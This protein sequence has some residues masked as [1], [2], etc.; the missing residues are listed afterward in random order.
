MGVKEKFEGDVAVLKVSGKMMGGKETDEV[1]EKIKSLVADDVRKVIIDLSKVKWMNSKGIGMLMSSFT[2][3]AKESG[4]LK[5]VGVTEKVN[6]LLMITQ[7]ITFFEHFD[8]IDRAL[9]AFKK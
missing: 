7:I 2:T 5:L 8:S 9:A 3:M 4:E 6:S 1:H